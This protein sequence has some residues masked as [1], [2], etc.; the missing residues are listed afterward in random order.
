MPWKSQNYDADIIVAAPIG[1]TG[2]ASQKQHGVNIGDP[3]FHNRAPQIWVVIRFDIL[4]FAA[5]TY[6][7]LFQKICTNRFPVVF[8]PVSAT[9]KDSW[10]S[11]GV[12]D[13]TP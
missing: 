10:S 12:A 5:N 8:P 1:Q 7:K 13:A 3:V 4:R 2:A 11:Q 6:T 9:G